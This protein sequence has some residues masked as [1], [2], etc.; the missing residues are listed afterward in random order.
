MTPEE[1]KS[2]H[3]TLCENVAA[4][5]ARIERLEAENERLRAAL[6]YARPLVEKWC[7]YQGNNQAFFRETLAP[8]DEALGI[9][10]QQ[11]ARREE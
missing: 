10:C 6:T 11:Q 1:Y 7:H 8:I 2:Q 5:G 4:K 9:S 3:A